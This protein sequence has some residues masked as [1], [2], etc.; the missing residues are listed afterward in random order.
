VEEALK[1]VS[2]AEPDGSVRPLC[3]KPLPPRE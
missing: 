2:V 3:K 1:G